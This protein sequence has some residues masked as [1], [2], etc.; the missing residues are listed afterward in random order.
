MKFLENPDRDLREEV[1]RKIQERR[2]QDKE[3]LNKLFTELVK[4]RDQIA[5]NAGF[6]NYR[7]Y[8]FV[9][10][11]RFDYT[12]EDCFRFHDSVKQHVLPLVEIINQYKKKK[13]GLDTL[14]PWDMEAEPAGQ[15]HCILLK[16]VR[17]L[18][19]KTV[20]C[21]TFAQTFLCRLPADDE[22]NE[23]L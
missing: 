8:K 22:K 17:N 7:D 14:R 10:M 20:H 9:E 13:L 1:Y 23:P 21:F 12:K 3:A 18:L 16:P 2:L 4:R 19:E 6:A 5:K 15:N 11:G